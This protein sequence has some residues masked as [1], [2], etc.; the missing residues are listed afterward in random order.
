MPQTILAIL[1]LMITITLSLGAQKQTT[2][3]QEKMIANELE[4]MATGVA[5]EAMERIRVRA[6]DE[7]TT[8]GDEVYTKDEFEHPAEWEGRGENW[9]CET[10]HGSGSS[11]DCDDLDDYHKM[12]PAILEFDMGKDP[13]GNALNFPFEVEVRVTYV[14][15]D[16]EAVSEQTYQKQVTV[17]VQDKPQ[18]G[19]RTILKRP[20]EL[21]R[22]F[23]YNF[24][25]DG[26]GHGGGVFTEVFRSLDDGGTSGGG[27][28][29]PEEEEPEEEPS[30]GHNQGEEDQN[31]YD[32]ALSWLEERISHPPIRAE[33][34]RLAKEKL[35]SDELAGY[36]N[37]Q[38]IGNIRD[39]FD[40]TPDHREAALNWY[41]ND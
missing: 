22:T 27:E 9:T 37:K 28:E 8:S 16:L 12:K 10:F 21:Q 15:E 23:A 2:R 11:S 4:V 32:D 1:A 20:I 39:Y 38:E 35:G 31:R 40:R 30:E 41:E 33:Y 36:I 14:D 34:K 5:L 18:P 3:A 24:R 29:P 19:G 7:K 13:G 25:D 17:Y 6:F 26:R